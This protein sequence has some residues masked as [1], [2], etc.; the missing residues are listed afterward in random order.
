MIGERS[1]RASTTALRTSGVAVAVCRDQQLCV[2]II[3][4]TRWIE[5]STQ[6]PSAEEL[7]E[8]L[9][10]TNA[11]GAAHQGGKGDTGKVLAQLGQMQVR[12]PEV[13][14]CT[15]NRSELLSARCKTCLRS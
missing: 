9:L 15:C 8:V 2:Q 6:F 14:A 7:A 4:G 10:G 1:A 5:S 12:W 11:P 3:W 13:V